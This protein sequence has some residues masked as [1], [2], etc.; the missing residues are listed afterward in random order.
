MLDSGIL[1]SDGWQA[2]DSL[3]ALGNTLPAQS[4][5][6]GNNTL[7]F[8]FS[9]THKVLKTY[10]IRQSR[11][12][13]VKK[14]YSQGRRQSYKT[15]NMQVDAGAA[16]QSRLSGSSGDSYMPSPLAPI[17]SW[18]AE[19]E[20]P[21]Q[22]Q[23][24]ADSPGGGSDVD[25]TDI[26]VMTPTSPERKRTPKPETRSPLCVQGR[27]SSHPPP[28][29]R[30]HAPERLMFYCR[31]ISVSTA[32]CSSSRT[33]CPTHWASYCAPCQPLLRAFFQMDSIPTSCGMHDPS[34][35]QS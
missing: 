11:Y 3:T 23:V 13:T 15:V 25:G 7:R 4:S 27:Q 10:G 35:I 22:R 26:A 17:S 1:P 28:P 8:F 14:L 16:E 9:M 24:W 34:S 30:Q 12:K 20:T 33:C 18:D 19:S 29:R 2:T 32:P 31:T 6:L 21:V 5:P